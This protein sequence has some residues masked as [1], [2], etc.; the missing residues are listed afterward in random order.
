[1]RSRTWP[2]PAATPDLAQDDAKVNRQLRTAVGG[3]QPRLTLPA[4]PTMRFDRVAAIKHPAGVFMHFP[5]G[6]HR[7]EMSVRL[8]GLTPVCAVPLRLESLTD[9]GGPNV[10]ELRPGA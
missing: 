7:V 3:I 1:L 8:S 6:R 4:A 2:G 10:Q 5:G 9:T